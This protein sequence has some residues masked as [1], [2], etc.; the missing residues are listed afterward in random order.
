MS[1]FLVV[2]GVNKRNEFCTPQRSVDYELGKTR[3]I[4]KNYLLKSVGTHRL[5]PIG[6]DREE[7]E[8]MCLF[9]LSGLSETMV[10]G[11]AINTHSPS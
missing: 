8:P 4:L 5:P 10:Q 6:L 3:K 11:W 1:L 2:K 9:S 7:R